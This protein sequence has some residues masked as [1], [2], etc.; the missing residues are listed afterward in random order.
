MVMDDLPPLNALRVFVVAAKAG[1]YVEAARMLGVTHGAVSRQ[2]DVL[3]AW[4]GH[5]LFRRSGRR[6][7]TTPIGDV[8]AN[9]VEHAFDRLRSA[10]ASLGRPEARRILR[11]SAPTSFAMRW[12]IPRLG[13]FQQRHPGVDVVVTTVS[14]VLDDLRGGFDVAI[15]RGSSSGAAWPGHTAVKVLEDVDTVIMSPSLFEERPIRTASDIAAHTLL[16]T[17]TRAGDWTDW[18]SAAGLDSLVTRPRQL[19]DHFYVTRQAVVDGLGIGIGP[20]PMLAIDVL[21]GR[22]VTPLP[23][24]RVRRAGY[25]AMVP[26]RTTAGSAQDHFVRWL[27]SQPLGA[28]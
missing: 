21:A 12:L 5:R 20:L 11:V 15:R 22:L 14:T 23:G 24:I 6:M 7:V 26:D 3:E 18:L 8:F 16:G 19:F 4:L 2:M 10:T 25:V 17:E 28:E 1:S 9:E 13:D 27:A